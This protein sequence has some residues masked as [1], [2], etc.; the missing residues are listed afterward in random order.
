MLSGTLSKNTKYVLHANVSDNGWPK[1]TSNIS[2]VIRVDSYVPEEVVITFYLDINKEEYMKKETIFLNLLTTVYKSKYPTSYVKRWCIKKLSSNSIK[3]DVY[4]I[5]NDSADE[6]TEINNGKP[7]LLSSKAL[8][9]VADASGKPGIEISGFTW[10]EFSIRKV[11]SFSPFKSDVPWIQTTIG[12]AVT[13]TCS[14][15]GA[16]LLVVGIILTSKYCRSDG[17]VEPKQLKTIKPTR[18]TIEE[19]TDNDEMSE[20]FGLPP[21][22]IIPTNQLP[23]LMK[24]TFNQFDR[25]DNIK[26]NPGKNIIKNRNFNGRVV[27]KDGNIFE[28]NTG[29]NER[30][31]LKVSR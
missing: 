29:A 27:D 25:I 10:K 31:I 24:N 30:K 1:L 6:E 7:F 8:T 18:V 12:I 16:A 19:S 28:Y 5:E 4:V 22:I 3:L 9:L 17:T 26:T 11:T 23:P 2:A 15:V 21:P 14:L 20:K 13:V